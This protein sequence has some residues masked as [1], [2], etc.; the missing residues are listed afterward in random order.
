MQTRTASGVVM[1]EIDVKTLSQTI[2]SL[3]ASQEHI[4]AENRMLQEQKEAARE[5][6]R[7]RQARLKGRYFTQVI[8][9]TCQELIRRKILTPAEKA[10]L[11]SILPFLQHKTNLVV[12][13][14]KV[15]MNIRQLA[16]LAGFST[17]HMGDILRGL[18]SKQ[19]LF[20]VRHGRHIGVALNPEY[21]QNGVGVKE[22]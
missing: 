9:G 21:F 7:K 5:K 1:E 19:I 16:E 18:E 6:A 15:L 4:A 11:I 14:K 22:L 13:E 2:N 8:H 10:V 3:A 20:K 17:R 12:D